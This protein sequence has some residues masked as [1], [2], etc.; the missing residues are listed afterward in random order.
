MK[1]KLS[2]LA[3]PALAG[4]VREKSIRGAM[5]EIMNCMYDGATMIDLHLSC[6]EATDVE[7]L[8]N[9][10]TSTKLPVLALNYN[11]TYIWIYSC[12]RIIRC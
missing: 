2:Q 7:S 8:K 6:L 10:I 5:A 11:N 3:A 12:K 9:I 4:V 1:Q